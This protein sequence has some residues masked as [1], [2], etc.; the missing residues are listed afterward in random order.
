MHKHEQHIQAKAKEN[1]KDLGDEIK[2]HVSSSKT[3]PDQ[4]EAT[5]AK[6]VGESLETS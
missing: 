2:D 3:S 5:D 4:V 1:L 6:P